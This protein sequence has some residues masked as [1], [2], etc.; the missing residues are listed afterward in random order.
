EEGAHQVADGRDRQRQTELE[1]PRRDR[2]RDRVGGVVESVG[3][4]EDQGKRDGDH[5]RRHGGPQPSVIRTVS[6][7][8]A[9]STNAAIAELS[10][11]DTARTSTASS[12]S[13]SPLVRW[14]SSSRR[15]NSASAASCRISAW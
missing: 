2:D 11:S 13:T 3:E 12:G 10:S 5:Q 1:R 15:W 7:I 14:T 9:T 6:T 8:S 4:G